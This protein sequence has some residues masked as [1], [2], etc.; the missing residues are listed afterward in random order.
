M[1]ERENN[2]LSIHWQIGREF[3]KAEPAMK[4]SYALDKN[5]PIFPIIENE[6]LSIVSLSELQVY[7]VQWLISGKKE[8]RAAKDY[9]PSERLEESIQKVEYSRWMTEKAIEIL[10]ELQEMESLEK[11]E[12]SK[13]LVELNK[14]IRQ[15]LA[16]YMEA[17]FQL[18]KFKFANPNIE[19][20]ERIKA[21]IEYAAKVN[22]MRSAEELKIRY[23]SLLSKEHLYAKRLEP[24]YEPI[25]EA[26]EKMAS[27]FWEME[28]MLYQL[29]D[30]YSQYL[31][32]AY[33]TLQDYAASS[34]QSI[35]IADLIKENEEIQKQTDILHDREINRSAEIKERVNLLN[36]INSNLDTI[37][38]Q[39]NSMNEYMQNAVLEICKSGLL[40]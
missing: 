11:N 8:K 33:Q 22:D 16:F 38:K 13:R 2:C 18:Y 26:E 40:S 36:E 4:R 3:L 32:M 21:S 29:N 14:T 9:V 28:T 30:K 35:T 1:P 7:K 5:A 15:A 39:Q 6:I 37:I 10:F 19:Q 34:K 12:Q 25:L 31:F 23:G 27:A 20:I 24:L 17:D